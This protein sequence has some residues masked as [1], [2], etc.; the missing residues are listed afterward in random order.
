LPVLRRHQ[1]VLSARVARQQ[2][3]KARTIAGRV[4]GAP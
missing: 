1:P 4:M 2:V 3:E